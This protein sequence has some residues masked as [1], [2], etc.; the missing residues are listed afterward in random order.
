MTS[1]EAM[2]I[3][4]LVELCLQINVVGKSEV[5]FRLYP[6]IQTIDIEVCE[7][8]WEKDKPIKSYSCYYDYEKYERLAGSELVQT[9]QEV[10]EALEK[11]LREDMQI[12]S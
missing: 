11:I 2:K 10:V 6:H 8:Q 7:G 5:D 3:K 4:R 1:Q 12:W 9:Y